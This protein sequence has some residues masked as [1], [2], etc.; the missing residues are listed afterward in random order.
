MVMPFH[1]REDDD[2]E[3]GMSRGCRSGQLPMWSE[4]ED[5]SVL[6]VNHFKSGEQCQVNGA[7]GRHRG[8]SV[9]A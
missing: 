7:A 9:R 6:L 5:R 3:R 4:A 8:D 1:V 2:G